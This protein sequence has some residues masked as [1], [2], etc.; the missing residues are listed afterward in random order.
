MRM[1]MSRRTTKLSITR[2]HGFKLYFDH[3]SVVTNTPHESNGFPPLHEHRQSCLEEHTSQSI[4]AFL[5]G[6]IS[7]DFGTILIY[8]AETA[9]SSRIMNCNSSARCSH[10]GAWI[11]P[12]FSATSLAF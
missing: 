2:Q 9:I 1:R 7:G 10:I 3:R 11:V 5:R 6:A 12:P 4:A 8:R